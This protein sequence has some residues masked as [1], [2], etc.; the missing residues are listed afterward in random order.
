V[1]FAHWLRLQPDS[2]GAYD[3]ATAVSAD[4]G[5][6]WTAAAQMNED[7]TEAEHGFV[8]SFAWNEQIAA[9]WLDGRELA[10]WSFDEPDALLGVSLRLARYANDGSVLSREIADALV[11]DCC[12]PDTA[13]TDAGPIVIYRDRTEAEI[14][15]VVVRRHVGGG[16]SEP[17]GVGN[18][19]WHIEGCPVNGPVVAAR[20]TEVVAAWFTAANGH[21]RVRFARSDDAGASF[22]AALDIET[23]GALGQPAIVLDANGRALVSWWRRGTDGGIDLMLRRVGRD[24]VSDEPLLIGH[25]AVG[26]PVTVPQLVT[27]DDD[28]L[29]AWTSLDDGGTIR[30]RR[31]AGLR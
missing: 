4:A 9:F 7:A 26:Q 19:G 12:Q 6:S 10:N 11:C 15:D 1:W 3:I 8:S 13:M 20:G 18:E 16:W 2:R 27:I 30:L 5:A 21:S 14:R 22:A 25:E 28:Y 17:I 29:I 23:R 24:G 31:L